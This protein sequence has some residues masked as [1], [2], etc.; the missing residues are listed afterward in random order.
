MNTF[1]EYRL[2]PFHANDTISTFTLT[3]MLNTLNINV[4]VYRYGY[5]VYYMHYRYIA[6]I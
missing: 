5:T 3:F 2:E 6:P 4:N 1:E